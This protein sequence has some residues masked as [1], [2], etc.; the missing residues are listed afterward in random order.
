MKPPRA[1]R[2]QR[3]YHSQHHKSLHGFGPVFGACP[4]VM[5]ECE[6]V[7]G[8]VFIALQMAVGMALA[9]AIAM[10]MM[11]VEVIWRVD[12]AVKVISFGWLVPLAVTRM[13]TAG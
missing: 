4:L 10:P 1:D 8:A 12:A 9:I 5:V 3:D 6:M 7:S 11:P 13:T 2:K